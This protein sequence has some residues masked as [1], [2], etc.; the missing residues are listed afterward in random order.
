MKPT[1][2]PPRTATLRRKPV[3]YL[4][5]TMMVVSTTSVMKRLVGSPAV[6]P[7]PAIQF[8][9]T[10]IRL[11]PVAVITVPVT[12]GGKSLTIRP[13]K[14]ASKMVMSPATMMAPNMPSS[15]T[16]GLLTITSMGGT[17][18]NVTPIIMGKRIPNFQN[19]AD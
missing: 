16:S 11:I 6:G 19:P 14:G 4:V 7:R 18:A 13:T 2:M 9:P 8:T 1:P 5:I 15:P 17:A 3:A 12:T 10:G